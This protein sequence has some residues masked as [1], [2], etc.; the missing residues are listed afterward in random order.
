MAPTTSVL[1]QHE[2]TQL[3]E[4]HQD[5]VSEWLTWL[6]IIVAGVDFRERGTTRPCRSH[7]KSESA[8]VKLERERQHVQPL[9]H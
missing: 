3:R 7:G 1:E 4:R 6:A 8:G 9:Q 5:A 2:R